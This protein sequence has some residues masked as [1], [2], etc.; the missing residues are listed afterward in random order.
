M[1]RYSLH[2]DLLVTH[3]LRTG[4]QSYDRRSKRVCGKTP[5]CTSFMK[6][7]APTLNTGI[8]QSFRETEQEL[9][10]Q[11]TY[12]LH[13]SF[14]CRGRLDDPQ[15]PLSPYQ[16][17]LEI[18]RDHVET[19]CMGKADGVRS[20]RVLLGAL[21]CGGCPLSTEEAHD[22]HPRTPSAVCVLTQCKCFS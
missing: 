7:S 3:T 11:Y 18:A 17:K 10:Q 14:H 20:H 4:R 12:A 21:H 5:V 1:L 16:G 9:E 13:G 8:P 6:H 22:A 15:H 2:K 19:F